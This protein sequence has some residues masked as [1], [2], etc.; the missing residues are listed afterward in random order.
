M[1]TIV[2]TSSIKAKNSQ[3]AT[4]SAIKVV[5]LCVKRKPTKKIGG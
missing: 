2:C 1:Q 3:K 4:M 5:N